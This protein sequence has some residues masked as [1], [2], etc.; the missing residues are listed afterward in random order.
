MGDCLVF[1]ED[2]NERNVATQAILYSEC[3][4]DKNEHKENVKKCIFLIFHIRS[5]FKKPKPTGILVK[6]KHWAGM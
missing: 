1:G 5:G 6:K 2:G 3:E 4:D